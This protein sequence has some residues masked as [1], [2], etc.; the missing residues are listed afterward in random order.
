MVGAGR[1]GV[2]AMITSDDDQVA[3]FKTLLNFGE[4]TIELL[5][6]IGISAW[7]IAVTVDHVKLDQVDKHQAFE[8]FF[9]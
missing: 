3:R 7:V 1:G 9:Q 8:I 5:E 6:R 2:N 4:V